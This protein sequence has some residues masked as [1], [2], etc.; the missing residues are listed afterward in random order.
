MR[1]L[2][3]ADRHDAPWLVSKLVPGVAAV[4]DDVV[5][6]FIDAVRQP[7]I[8]HELPQV[9]DGVQLGAAGW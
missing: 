1:P 7:V 9:L 4:L 2:T 8:A 3:Q 5:V 6:G